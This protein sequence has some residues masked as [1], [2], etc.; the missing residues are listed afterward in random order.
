MVQSLTA[1][2]VWFITGSQHLYGPKTLHQVNQHST[3]IAGYF[4]DQD[5]IPVKIVF[6][7]VLTSPEEIFQITQEANHHTACIGLIIWMHT[8]S[9][10]KMWIGGLKN[11]S[12][13]R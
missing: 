1:F 2:E 6:K 11:L 10:S 4:N 9:P 3:Q 8:F 5:T 7:P 13:P 12:K